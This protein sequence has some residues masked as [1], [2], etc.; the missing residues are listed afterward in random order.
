VDSLGGK[1]PAED[2]KINPRLYNLDKD[3][4]ETTNVASA[5]PEV[6]EKLTALAA[7]MNHDIGGP[8]PSARRPAGSVANPQPLYPFD[9]PKPQPSAKP[10]ALDKLKPGDAVR[11]GAAPQIAGQA[12]S[13]TCQ[14][15][16]EQ[17][18]AVIVAQGGN[19]AG[20][21]LH[22][23]DGC[24]VFSV[25]TGTKD[26]LT[27]I[28]SEPIKGSVQIAA[29]LGKDGTMTLAVGDQP[30]VKGKAPS[31]I[32]RQ[33]Q[34]DFCLGHDNREPVAKYAKV[35]PFEGKVSGLKVTVP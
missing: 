35:A 10:A 30:V 17:R 19:A 34:E 3:I 29:A 8:S 14:V 1:E 4:G 6:V 9:E 28:R 24:V 11:S 7:K 33:P 21:A 23:H 15:E 13:L 26:A 16:T 5:H 25:R 2:S 32:P 20:Y 18:D 31:S 22:L 12:F 27:E